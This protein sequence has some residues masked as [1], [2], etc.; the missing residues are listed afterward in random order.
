MVK[1]GVV[2]KQVIKETSK[3]ILLIS[4]MS[5]MKKIEEVKIKIGLFDLPQSTD[6]YEYD[7]YSNQVLQSSIY[8]T[9]VT[10][11]SYG[12]IKPL[13]ATSW[14]FSDDFKVWK[15]KIRKDF[16]FSNGEKIQAQDILESFKR[17]A[18]LVKKNKSEDGVLNRLS[19]F[20]SIRDNIQEIEGLSILDDELIMKFNSG[21]KNIPELI[22]FGLYAV[23]HRE[24][25]DKKSGSWKNKH[26][27]ISSS[28]YLLEQKLG[29]EVVIL[30][31]NKEAKEKI[32]HPNKFDLIEIVKKDS[33]ADLDA[34]YGVSLE[35]NE[36]KNYSFL[37]GVYTGIR[38]LRLNNWEDEK[39][40]LN[41][42]D[43]RRALRD[44]FYANVKKCSFDLPISFFPLTK[45]EPVTNYQIVK[46]VKSSEK[47]NVVLVP[48]DKTGW[49][50]CI[51]E[52]LVN[53]FSELGFQVNSI[54]YENHSSAEEMQESAKRKAIDVYPT[55]TSILKK[56]T[57]PF[58]FFSK[59]G[60]MLPDSSG[61]I[62]KKVKSNEYEVEEI[63][64]Y[65]WDDAIV[66]PLSHFS[67][68]VYY[69]DHVDMSMFSSKMS[70][71]D[72]NWIGSK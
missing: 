63:N 3:L 12:S 14:E 5:C 39:F 8:S 29:S 56:E 45:Q 1:V 44:R 53:S 49:G 64:Q 34:L 57:I 22:S 13:L 47:V 55:G 28:S 68:G 37:G 16:N 60:I 65:L 35:K 2:L 36:F 27:A 66:W 32:G 59:E 7:D 19:G 70:P 23:V 11:N 67:R 51:N 20:D 31:L 54:K 42:L 43:L 50:T 71:F 41:S 72:F 69:K 30:R 15:F 26:E 62:K 9:L 33:G 21:I 48:E 6:P 17:M 4:L 25:Y 46:N 58:M 18:F 24:T 10:I 38:Y 40:P 52:Q 61:E